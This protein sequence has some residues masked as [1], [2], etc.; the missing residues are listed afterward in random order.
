MTILLK[1]VVL[2]FIFEITKSCVVYNNN[3]MMKMLKPCAS[4][5]DFVDYRTVYN[6]KLAFAHHF[7]CHIIHNSTSLMLYSE[8]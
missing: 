4:V 5:L 2:T 6:I 3:Y 1:A 7:R 8:V